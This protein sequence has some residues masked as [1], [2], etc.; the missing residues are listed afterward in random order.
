MEAMTVVTSGVACAP[1]AGQ[2]SSGDR[3]MVVEFPGGAL[4]A[5][6]DGLGH[7]DEASLAA[8]EAELVLE[9]DP[10][11]PVDELVH[12]CHA[13]LKNTRGA[14]MTLASFQQGAMTWVGVG[15]VEAVLVRPG[16]IDAVPM[17]GGIVGYSLPALVARRLTVARGDTLVL[18]TDGIRHGF[19]AEVDLREPQTI[20]DAVLAKY[21]KPND[22]A[23]VVVARY[24]GGAA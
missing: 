12:R 1:L 13:R 17:R 7:G 8:H 11:A 24:L 3:G 15:N 21:A 2:T 4:V 19:R 20:A 9:D 18:A 6:I 22:D 5:A 14:V 10:G 23:C 16:G